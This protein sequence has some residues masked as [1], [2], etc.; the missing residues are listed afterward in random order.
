MSARVCDRCSVRWPKGEEFKKCPGCGRNTQ[1]RV[2]IE[3]ED[4]WEDRYLDA[5]R[6]NSAMPAVESRTDADRLDRF[7]KAGLDLA[8]ALEFAGNRHVDLSLFE[9]LRGQGCPLE[10]AVEIVGPI[11]S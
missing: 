5:Q 2:H 1:F 7:Q 3:A 4:G 11:D 6:A 10:T 8:R 9:R